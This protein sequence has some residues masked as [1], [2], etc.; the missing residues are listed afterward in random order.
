[1]RVSSGLLGAGSVWECIRFALIVTGVFGIGAHASGDYASVIWFGSPQ[2]VIA[3]LLFMI[4]LYPIRY[5]RM[6]AVAVLGKVLAIVSGIVAAVPALLREIGGISISPEA[7]VILLVLFGDLL[8]LA[9]LL[10]L[11]REPARK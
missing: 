4:A 8:L 1:M 10:L 9:V 7:S 5:R 11:N 2:L 6:I 3:G